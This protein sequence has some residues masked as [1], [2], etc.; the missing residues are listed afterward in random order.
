MEDQ[1]NNNN[2]RRSTPGERKNTYRELINQIEDIRKAE[3][4]YRC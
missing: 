2:V 3:F 4:V 1:E